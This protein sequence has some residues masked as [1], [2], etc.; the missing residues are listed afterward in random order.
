MNRIFNAFN[1]VPQE[2]VDGFLRGV[3]FTEYWERV[4]VRLNREE[5]LAGL[6]AKN[7]VII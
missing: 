2:S 4:C 7:I 3:E 1:K 6:E 5:E